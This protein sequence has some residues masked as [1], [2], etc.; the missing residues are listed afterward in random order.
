MA[1]NIND[2]QGSTFV[3]DNSLN[4]PMTMDLSGIKSTLDSI[5]KSVA[6]LVGQYQ[7]AGQ[8]KIE[9][10]KQEK[11]GILGAISSKVQAPTKTAADY[12]KERQDLQTSFLASQGIDQEDFNQKNQL[13][14]QIASLNNQLSQMELQETK[15]KDDVRQQVGITSGYAN[16]Q[17]NKIER[18][19]LYKKAM[20]ATQGAGLAAQYRVK[21]GEI[22][23]A[24][25]LFT[26][27]I[28]YATTQ[29][30]QEVD[31]YK[32][33]LNFYAGI[34]EA[35]RKFLQDELDKKQALLKPEL[36]EVGGNLY[37]YTYNPET[38][39]Y[40]SQLLQSGGTGTVET[41]EDTFTDTVNYL[42]QLRDSGKLTDFSYKEQ[43]NAL[44]QVGGYSEDQRGQ[45]ESMVN[46]A[47][48]GG[49][50]AQQAVVATPE[51]TTQSWLDS[52]F[53]LPSNVEGTDFK[54]ENGRRVEL[55]PSVA[56][57]AGENLSN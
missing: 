3:P 12:I 56:E 29:T 26:E 19:Y 49:I 15:E 57:V 21:A 22:E 51:E 10:P 11:T 50:I 32:W 39:S 17:T 42:K 44:M 25:K 43:I 48:E 1:I 37:Q 8:T 23:E 33:A 52:L 18:D 30:R 7:Q 35:D 41:E 9:Q 34:E 36:R 28:N 45:V 54:I 38:N 53:E 5:T 24:N 6:D 27:S 2:T 31:D 40:S 46:Q 55:K 16:A 47:M 20:I 14:T 13:A 4:K